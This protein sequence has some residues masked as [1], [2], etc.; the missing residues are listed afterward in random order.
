MRN[1]LKNHERHL[2]CVLDG[3]IGCRRLGMTPVMERICCVVVETVIFLTKKF[4]TLAYQ[5]RYF[6]HRATPVS[7]KMVHDYRTRKLAQR[8]EARAVNGGPNKAKVKRLACSVLT[9]SFPPVSSSPQWPPPLLTVL[10]SPT[11]QTRCARFIC[12]Y[13]EGLIDENQLSSSDTK[14]SPSMV[15][16]LP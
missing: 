13:L 15:P 6:A 16:T 12:I 5:T 11:S 10:A 1:P 3:T 8:V 7:R 2:L 14:L 9:F 4:L